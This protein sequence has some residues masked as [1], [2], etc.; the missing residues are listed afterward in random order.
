MVMK[1]IKFPQDEQAHDKIV[2]WWYWN[3]HLEGEDGNHYA[4]M[5]CLFKVK[6]NK[7]NL[8]LF[9]MPLKKAYFS[10]SILSDVKEQKVYPTIDYISL[11][12]SDS[13]KHPRFFVEYVDTDFLN[14]FTVSSMEETAPLKYRLRAKDFDL[15]FSSIKKPLLENGNGYLSLGGQD[16]YYYSL[17]NLKT[18]GVIRIK[19]KEIKVK[20]KSWMDH[21][22]ADEPYIQDK[23]N[24][25]SLQLDDNTEIVCF[26][27]F[28]QNKNYFFAGI[29]YPNGK[30]EHLS[31]VYFT[32]TGKEW[33]SPKTKASY[34]L[35][36]LI[37]IPSKKIQ[38]RVKPLI[39][40]QE[41]VFGT[42]NYWEGPLVVNG[43]MGNK[44]VTGQGFLELMGRPSQYKTYNFLKESFKKTVKTLQKKIR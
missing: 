4:F 44:K 15:T 33:V 9:K 24:W 43:K 20:G 42:I 14:G 25:F 18:E 22:W 39:R 32:S 37:E 8:P 34:P 19:G 13:F 1:Q 21:Q 7:V 3:G 6:P 40:N 10:H 17:T 36:W 26:E 16:Y 31:E 2:E 23:W 28:C 41:M 27:L 38:L 35:D 30:S 12:S 5:D 29:S 11:V